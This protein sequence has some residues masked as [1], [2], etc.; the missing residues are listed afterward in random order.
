MDA[1]TTR[2]PRVQ[3]STTDHDRDL[4]A[5][6]QVIADIETGFNTKDQ[7]LS[8]AHFAENASGVS[9]A[10]VQVSGYDALLEAHRAGLAGALRDQFAR[11]ELADLVFVRPDVAIAHKRAWATTSDGDPIDVDH[12]MVALY[13]LVKEAGRW[14]VVARQN[15][16]VQV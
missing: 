8:V 15:T 9:V 4:A 7:A 14:W 6:T 13:V 1:A 3:D 12:A 10:G 5:I 2:P 16:L 11:Y